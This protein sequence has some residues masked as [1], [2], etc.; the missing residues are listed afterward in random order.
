M[1]VSHSR[2]CC[3]MRHKLDA[4][5]LSAVRISL[6]VNGYHRRLVNALQ[7]TTLIDK[8]HRNT[9]ENLPNSRTT[10][11]HLLTSLA[12]RTAHKQSTLNH[13]PPQ[14]SQRSREET[15]RTQRQRRS[16]TSNSRR[17]DV[18]VASRCYCLPPA[19][20]HH[21]PHTIRIASSIKP[22]LIQTIQASDQATSG[23]VNDIIIHS[24]RCCCLGRRPSPCCLDA[25]T[26]TTTYGRTAC[27][28]LFGCWSSW[29][30]RSGPRSSPSSSSSRRH[31][32]LVLCRQCC[33]S[34]LLPPLLRTVRSKDV[35]GRETE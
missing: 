26:T 19:V 16:K 34:F 25:T 32:S 20:C 12:V 4:S 13:Q 11:K 14:H 35:S 23:N 9:R 10:P 27:T 28:K 1:V 2:A 7:I 21:Q 18:A 17:V 8:L 5:S 15:S 6:P 33:V 24:R 29:C 22:L 30:R 3:R 31:A